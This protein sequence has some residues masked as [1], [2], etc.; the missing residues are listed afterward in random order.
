[1]LLPH[2]WLAA[3]GRVLSSDGFA[4]EAGSSLLLALPELA[5]P[6]LLLPELLAGVAKASSSLLS[7]ELL[8]LAL[9]RSL[10]RSG[11]PLPK[12]SP[13]VDSLPEPL[14]SSSGPPLVSSG[15]VPLLSSRLLPP[16]PSPPVLSEPLLAGAA[17]PPQF[18]AFSTSQAPTDW[19]TRP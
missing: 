7:P 12:A 14:L 5:L 3:R 2:D 4:A 18:S 11:K 15:L 17:S 13:S 8:P 16:V 10:P 19:L 6:E 9:S 1:M